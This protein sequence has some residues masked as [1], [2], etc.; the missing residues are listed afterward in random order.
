MG[1]QA[2][3][4]AGMIINLRQN[5]PGKMWL[6]HLQRRNLGLATFLEVAV[7]QQNKTKPS[8]PPWDARGELLMASEETCQEQQITLKYWAV[9]EGA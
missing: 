8:A 6:L 2:G 9:G 4:L 1:N 3:F 5:S 7:A